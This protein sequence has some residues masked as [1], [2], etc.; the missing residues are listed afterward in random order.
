MLLV[1]LRGVP[2]STAASGRAATDR[3]LQQIGGYLP[4]CTP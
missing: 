3:A 4:S 2:L 1:A